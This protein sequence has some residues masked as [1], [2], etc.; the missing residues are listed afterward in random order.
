MGKYNGMKADFF[1]KYTKAL[2]TFAE[3]G[4]EA[5]IEDVA[6][7]LIA[8]GKVLG[9][10]QGYNDGVWYIIKMTA[11][12]IGVGWVVGHLADKALATAIEE[13]GGPVKYG[14]FTFSKKEG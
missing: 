2:D 5:P 10:Q 7:A 9:Y 12:G 14:P 4:G 11:I 1:D 3:G 6:D 8:G 13:E